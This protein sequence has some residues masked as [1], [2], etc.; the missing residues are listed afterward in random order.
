[1]GVWIAQ[2]FCLLS[3]HSLAIYCSIYSSVYTFIY[4][5][6]PLS[7]H[8]SIFLC[9]HPPICL[10]IYPSI[11]LA[12]H[13][14][15]HHSVHPSIMYPMIYFKKSEYFSVSPSRI[16]NMFPHPALQ[17]GYGSLFHVLCK[18]KKCAPTD[19]ETSET[20]PQC[21]SVSVPPSNPTVVPAS[22]TRGSINYAWLALNR[23]LHW[24]FGTVVSCSTGL[25]PLWSLE[26][27]AIL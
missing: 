11:H 23:F 16:V 1:M 7:I 15:T 17:R 27:G 8:L 14:S 5:S 19:P 3:R 9:F 2:S 20:H 18:W 6:L 22:R 24:K 21:W 25:E 26:N 10:L 12:I 4:L 13:L